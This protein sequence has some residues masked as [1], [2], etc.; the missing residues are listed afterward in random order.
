MTNIAYKISDLRL[1]YRLDKEKTLALRGVQL[2]VNEGEFVCLSGPSGSGKTT[3][4]NIMGLIESGWDGKIDF[5]GQSLQGLSDQTAT[6]I[7]LF[8]L[9]F[10]FQSFF[11]FPTL[12]AAE[13]VEYFLI[14]QNVS[15]KERAIRVC[16]LST[17]STQFMPNMA[18]VKSSRRDTGARFLKNPQSTGLKMDLL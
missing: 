3:L 17:V 1:S 10:V 18:M 12:T 16:L 6:K 2:D 7:R 4:L 8:D 11:L 5:F 14:R 9:G 13:N 15:A